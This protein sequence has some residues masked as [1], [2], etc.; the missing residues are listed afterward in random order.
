M[1]LSVLKLVHEPE[2]ALG[3]EPEQPL[4]Q[5]KVEPVFWQTGP[6]PPQEVLQAPQRVVVVTSASQPLAALPSQSAKPTAQPP[7]CG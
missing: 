1:L 3:A 2:H 6:V 7:A 4:W 5:L